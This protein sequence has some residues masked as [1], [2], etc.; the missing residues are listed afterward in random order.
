MTVL[1]ISVNSCYL[2][3]LAFG[4]HIGG[5][6]AFRPLKFAI[7]IMNA[8]ETLVSFSIFVKFF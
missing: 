2:S 6:R 4:S 3:V 7:G 8:M 1:V 5:V